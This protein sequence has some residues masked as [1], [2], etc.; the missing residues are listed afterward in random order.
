[1][2]ITLED[3]CYWDTATSIPTEAVSNYHLLYR[4]TCILVTRILVI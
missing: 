4:P 3:V 1:M 2:S